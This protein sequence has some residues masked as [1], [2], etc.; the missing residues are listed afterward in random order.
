MAFSPDGQ[1]LASADLDGTVSTWQVPEHVPSG[2]DPTGTATTAA[3]SGRVVA[4]TGDKSEVR[5]WTVPASGQPLA[6]AA[7]P[8]TTSGTT[9]AGYSLSVAMSPDGSVIAI[10]PLGNQVQL[11]STR[12]PGR[13]PIRTLTAHGTL[14]VLAYRP[15]PG[16]A[17]VAAGDTNGNVYLWADNRPAPERITGGLPA[18]VATL[19]FRPDGN[20]LAATSPDGTLV[21]ARAEG[22]Q[23]TRLRENT[24]PVNPVK[25]SAFST[26]G[27]MLATAS[28]DGSIQLWTVSADGA[29]TGPTQ[30]TG[31]TGVATPV[32]F[33]ADGTLAASY[34]D[35]TIH[36]WD[37]RDPATPIALATISGLPNPTTAAW[38]P[39]TRVVL[40]AASDGTL[41]TWNTDPGAV[42][43]R[44][45]TSR[46]AG[47]ASTLTPSACPKG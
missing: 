15:V 37:V 20:L 26:D 31:P 35:G 14:T 6:S 24:G 36:L 13:R 4:T 40:G 34:E 16:G 7:I 42:A 33:S 17:Q 25:T 30:L 29:I 47:E 27:K 28:T 11:W 45:C 10:A 2:G 1:V 9:P 8:V 39:R 38:Q 18:A 32:A 41:M 5:L 23:W 44:I 43:S 3:A 19:T 21:L 22:R 12:S 46:L